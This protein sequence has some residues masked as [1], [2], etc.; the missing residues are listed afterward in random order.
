MSAAPDAAPRDHLPLRFYASLAALVLLGVALLL[1][2]NGNAGA[3]VAPALAVALV[4]A[5][6]RMPLRTTVLVWLSLAVVADYIPEVPYSGFWKG[7]LFPLGQAFYLNLNQLTGIGALRF[8][9]S[10]VIIAALCGV[11]V[12]RRATGRSKDAPS[13]IASALPGFVALMLV[14]VLYMYVR[15]AATGGNMKEAMW[16]VHQL[17]FT[18]LL[19]FL[20]ASVLRGTNDLVLLG[21]IVVVAACVR[22]A[23]SIYFHHA[24][25]VGQGIEVEY[26]V[27]HIDTLTFVTA[28]Q[29]LFFGLLEQPSLRRLVRWLPVALFITV[30]MVYN[31]RR[32][33][34]VS[35]V[36]G[37]AVG[38]LMMPWTPIRRW[39]LRLSL[40]ALPVLPLYFALGWNRNGSL[41]GPAQIVR[42]LIEG[43]HGEGI[44]DYRDLENHNI[45]TTWMQNTWLGNGLGKEFVLATNIPDIGFILPTW[46]YHPHN[47]LLWLWSNGGPLAFAMTW[48]FMMVAVYLG[49]RAYHRAHL[50]VQRT[51]MLVCVAVVLSYANQAFGDM[52]PLHWPAAL[53]VACV[54]VLMGQVAVETGVWPRVVHGRAHLAEPAVVDAAALR[55][56]PAR[57]A[58]PPR[59]S[60]PSPPAPAPARRRA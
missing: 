28:L 16:Q 42:S 36:E 58:P 40:M 35:L 11:A 50:P 59:P 31:D 32:L 14:G 46:R 24:F 57:P 48:L 34:Y 13:P 54:V 2:T 43:S 12:W 10:D 49:A 8:Q 1:V 44:T 22:S 20:F 5:V 53:Y 47:Q 15:G 52:G 30:G 25:V 39:A 33:A 56:P 4:W 38:V 3:A 45:I 29:V 21:R 26:T 27:T 41:W 17:A 23:L 19:V 9:G 55:A 60:Q 7:P 51:G 6:G 18:P 37:L